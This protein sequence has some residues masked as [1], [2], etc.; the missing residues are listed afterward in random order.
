MQLLT[1]FSL[2]IVVAILAWRA[3]ALSPSGAFGA[4]LTG[5]LIF[6]F[7]GLP[8]AALLLTF[9]IT[10]SALSRLFR[11][12]KNVLSEKFA[13]GSRRDIGQVLA[14]GGVGAG[15]AVLHVLFP[16]QNS[17]WVACA[18]AF[19]AVN[20]DTW[21]TELG[22]LSR[23]QPRLITSGKPVERGA[24]GAVSL[25]GYGAVLAGSSLIALVGSAFNPAGDT[26]V[27]LA[28]VILGGLAGATFDSILGAT[29]QAIYICP[30]CQKETERHP[31]HTC[32][33]ETR[34]L[35]GW[36]WLDN[37]WV[38]ALCSGVGAGAAVLVWA[39]LVG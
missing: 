16:H 27:F 38:N 19:A 17:W 5:G 4:S 13:K 29:V 14:N 31:H 30:T 3:G 22:V 34:P 39:L 36:R 37:D 20:A 11:S 35:R 21:A 10:S 7:G 8:W 6:G 2:G 1:G 23:A 15:L 25:L 24:S 32:G 18:G 33:T 12:H 9:F 28:A 26:A